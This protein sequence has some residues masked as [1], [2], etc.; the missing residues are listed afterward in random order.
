MNDDDLTPVGDL[1]ARFR[2]RSPALPDAGEAALLAPQRWRECLGDDLA[3]A[4]RPVRLTEGVLTIEATDAV[5][6]TRLRY[7]EGAIKALLN[8]AADRDV[9]RR[10]VVRVTRC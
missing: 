4:G 1:L 7:A 2:R 3:E 8:E 9:V 10:V 5:G 6:A